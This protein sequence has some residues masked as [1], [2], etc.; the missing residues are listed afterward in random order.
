M[1]DISKAFDCVEHGTLLDKI[2][3]WGFP[4]TGL[5]TISVAAPSMSMWEMEIQGPT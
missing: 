1:L 4:A 2:E 3:F 5:P